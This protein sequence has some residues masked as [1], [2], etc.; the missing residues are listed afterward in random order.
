MGQAVGGPTSLSRALVDQRAT[1][2]GSSI[3]LGSAFSSNFQPLHGDH[4]RFRGFRAIGTVRKLVSEG[5]LDPT[6]FHVSTIAPAIGQGRIACD[7]T[8]IHVNRAN[9]R[10]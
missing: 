8:R 2:S 1:L 4:L 7:V 3:F 5:L 10:G 9:E 6:P